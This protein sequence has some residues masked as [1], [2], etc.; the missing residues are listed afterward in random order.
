MNA[1]N[2]RKF[3]SLT[4]ILTATFASL[5]LTAAF[6][7]CDDLRS[8]LDP[9]KPPSQTLKIGVIQPPQFYIGFLRGAEMARQEVNAE[10][11]VLGMQ[12]EFIARNNQG[13]DIFPTA[14]KTIE[15]AHELIETEGVAAILGPVFSTNSV[16]LGE[17]LTEAGIDIPILPASTSASVPQSHSHFALAG[18]NNLHQA[19]VLANFTL[20]ELG[21]RSVGIS[22]L[23]GDE[24][25]RVLTEGFVRDFEA[26]GGEIASIAAYEVGSTDFEPQIKVLMDSEPEA[27]FLSSFAP[28][29][30]L[31]VK[32][33]RAMGYDGQF[34]G[35]DGWD[36][37]AGF[38]SVLADNSPLNGSYYVANFFPGGDDPTANAFAEA[39]MSAHGIIADSGAAAGYDSMKLLAQA[40]E[41]AAAD[42]VGENGAT[43]LPD[44]DA[45]LAAL[46]ATKDYRGATAISHF[47]ENRL[48]VK[49]Y[50]VLTIEN[51]MPAFHRTWPDSRTDAGD[52][53]DGAE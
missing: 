18:A 51:G 8:I 5:F 42:M 29:V 6:S 33:A 27:I 23:E 49:E 43:A 14:E 48:A 24:Y 11:G 4:R 3:R 40:I 21:I 47:D 37:V 17:A 15:A 7:S 25:S 36:D 28:E 20:A 52:G 26:G 32:Q 10:G 2:R 13:A 19:N 44:A 9:Q 46:L 50:I 1:A 41:T 31:F 22:L 16:A 34:I 12:V 35:G 45:I 39:F 30:P 38:Y 53:G